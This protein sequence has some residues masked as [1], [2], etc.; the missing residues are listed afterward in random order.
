MPDGGRTLLQ[1]Y[2]DVYRMS[3]GCQGGQYLQGCLMDDAPSF[4]MTCGQATGEYSNCCKTGDF[5]GY[6]QG[7]GSFQQRNSHTRPNTP[8]QGPARKQVS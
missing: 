1:I 7:T 4:K 5:G 6:V 8:L 3:T 2:K